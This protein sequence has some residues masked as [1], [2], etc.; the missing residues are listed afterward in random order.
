MSG[1]PADSILEV[2]VNRTKANLKLIEQEVDKS[3]KDKTAQ[4]AYEVTQL[5]NSLFGLLILPEQKYHSKLGK[6]KDGQVP[7]FVKCIKKAKEEYKTLNYQNAME[8]LRNAVCHPQHMEILPPQG[9]ITQIV[10]RDFYD[11]HEY[12]C[13]RLEIDELKYLVFE[14]CEVLTKTIQELNGDL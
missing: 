3:G 9:D 10:L 12:F 7:I 13:V 6:I 4:N 14:L 8:H 11:G 5:L 2:F 1:Y